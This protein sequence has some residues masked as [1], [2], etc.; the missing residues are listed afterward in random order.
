MMHFFRILCSLIMLA[1]LPSF[2][3]ANHE[4][5]E[6]VRSI[7]HRVHH[8]RKQGVAPEDIVV[9]WDFHGVLT[10]QKKPEAVMNLNPDVVHVLQYLHKRKVP[11]LIATAWRDPSKVGQDL[12][13]LKISKYFDIKNMENNNPSL[14]KVHLGKKP[15]VVFEGYRN[16]RLVALRK[17]QDFGVYFPNKAFGVEWCY[18]Q[19]EFK[20]VFFI[21]DN[22]NNLNIFKSDFKETVH[23]KKN[24]K[25]NLYHLKS[26]P[27]KP[28]TARR[29]HSRPPSG[30]YNVFLPE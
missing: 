1:S 15:P 30:E 8:L 24:T 5:I 3:L 22:I 20:H 28:K 17:R 4:T 23:H 27:Q 9:V 2:V 10:K 11:Q 25:L 29:T 16:G 6:S 12:L 18:P 26:L 19:K 14:T 13:L 21:D 7:K